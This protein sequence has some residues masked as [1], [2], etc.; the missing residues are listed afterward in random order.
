[1]TG[2][3][4]PRVV[5]LAGIAWG[6]ALLTRGDDLWQAVQGRHPNDDERLVVGILGL[7]HVAQGT[8]QT[9]APGLMRRPVML[10]DLG[11]A[12]SMVAL[13]A[14]EPRYRRPALT[15]GAV[16]VASA[17]L[18]GLSHGARQARSAPTARSAREQHG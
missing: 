17:L 6:A 15:S 13:A 10:V 11:H 14:R 2:R 8:L 1:M 3:V 5:G 18:T 12:A 16:A 4:L 7:R 9:L